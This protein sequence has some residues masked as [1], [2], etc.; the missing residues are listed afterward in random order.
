MAFIWMIV[1][2]A[3]LMVMLNTSFSE[4]SKEEGDIDEFPDDSEITELEK[5]PSQIWGVTTRNQSRTDSPFKE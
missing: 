1:F 5:E 4:V 3:V 2:W